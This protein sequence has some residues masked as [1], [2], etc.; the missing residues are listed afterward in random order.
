MATLHRVLLAALLLAPAPS[1][2][3]D[4]FAARLAQADA[5]RSADP[6][7]SAA[8]L[9]GLQPDLGRAT[10]HQRQQVAY[11][12]AYRLAVFGNRPEEAATR[13]AALVEQAGDVDLRFRAGALAASSFAIA[14][15]F[16]ASLRILDRILPM[17]A[18]VADSAVRH[19]GLHAA[20][21][22]YHEMGQYRLSLRYADEILADEPAPRT[23]CIASLPQL[24]ARFRLGLLPVDD[25]P[26]GRAI[27]Q[28]LAVDEAMTA[29]FLRI[30]LARKLE[31]AGRQADALELLRQHLPGIEAI[32]YQRLSVDAHSLVAELLLHKGDLSLAAEHAELAIA[33]ARSFSSGLPLAAAHRVLYEVA[34]ARGDPA[35][36]LAHYRRYVEAD[37]AQPSD[38]RARDLAYAIVRD[39]TTGPAR[40]IELLGQQNQLLRLQHEVDRRAAARTRILV[41]VLLLLIAGIGGW[42]WWVAGRQPRDTAA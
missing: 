11:L 37:R 30:V 28:C 1:P 40:Q 12:E 26:L 20:A 8:L 10:L 38:A 19:A 34:E 13:A 9:A 27:D 32:G 2:A 36:A 39:E 42:T 35:A 18:D 29:S 23:R 7:R 22:L 24:D 25:G 41:L 3:Q 14:R 17:R 15:D 5:L 6:E 16:E 4:D 21:L 33:S 31:A